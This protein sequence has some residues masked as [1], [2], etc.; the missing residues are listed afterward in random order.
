MHP[1]LVNGG[2]SAEW[3][4]ENPILPAN[5]TGTETDTL[6]TK[7][8][9]GSSYWNSLK[10]TDEPSG[11]D[12]LAIEVSK[13]IIESDKDEN[14]CV[15]ASHNWGEVTVA[16]NAW[17]LHWF[18]DIKSLGYVDGT[19]KRLVNHLKFPGGKVVKNLVQKQFVSEY[20][21]SIIAGTGTPTIVKDDVTGMCTITIPAGTSGRAFLA[22]D[23]ISF[24]AGHTYCISFVLG[25]LVKPSAPSGN[26]LGVVAAPTVDFGQTTLDFTQ[27]A[28]N[29]R[30]AAIFQPTTT[31]SVTTRIGFGI[32]G[33]HTAGTSDAIAEILEIMIED[34]SVTGTNIPSEYVEP[35]QTAKF[36]SNYTGSLTTPTAGILT[37]T[38]NDSGP[39]TNNIAIFGDSYVNN[40]QD[41][42]ELLRLIKNPTVGVWYQ[43]WISSGVTCAGTRPSVYLAQFENKMQKLIDSGI[44]F[45]YVL[46]QSSLNT[47]VYSTLL[48]QDARIADDLL[49]IRNAAVWALNHGITPIFTTVQA[50]KS[51]AGAAWIAD[52]LYLAQQKMDAAIYALAAELGGAVFNIRASLEDS[53]TPYLIDATYDYGDGIHPNSTGYQKI[54]DDLH[55]FIKNL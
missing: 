21:Q 54:A 11:P 7:T 12:I 1:V 9:N 38:N 28:A 27:I 32:S 44:T 55:A 35:N 23:P 40:L 5:T 26:F 25:N 43:A 48:T 18:K 10:Y 46:L 41:Y 31:Q 20:S 19:S 47:V 16:E 4:L 13:A 22:M 39:M 45:N 52:S 33:N 14:I 36:L 34:L 17:C 30:M 24:L 8:G 37:L 29:S 42:P 51:G 2:T 53:T 3:A 6:R 15:D 49:A 50:W